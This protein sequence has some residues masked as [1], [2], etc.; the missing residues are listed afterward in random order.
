MLR[1][2]SILLGVT[3]G[4]AAY[5]AAELIRLLDKQGAMV[6]VV[7]TAAAQQFITP[8]TL[9]ALSGRPVLTDL[10]D[11]G[12]ESR[13]G[14]I[15]AAREADLILVAPATANLLA[16]MA[17]GLADDYLSTV[18][19]AATAPVIV[20]PAMNH[21]MYAN[22]ATQDN[23]RLL[24]NRGV[25]VVEPQAGELACGEEGQGRLAD[26]SL[27]VETAVRVLTPKSLQGKRVLVTAGPTWEPF[28]PV[29]FI[30]N[31][32][33]GKM[34]FALAVEAS[35]R[36]AHVDLVTGPTNLLDPPFL[37][38]HRVKTALEMDRVVRDLAATADVI[39]MSAAVSDYRPEETAPQK[40]KKSDRDLTIRLIRTPDILAGVGAVKRADQVLVGFAAETE[41]LIE[42]ATE[43]LRKKNL[44]FIVA[45]DLTRPGSGFRCDTNQVKILDRGGQ[46]DTLPCLTKNEVAR[47]ILDRVETLLQKV[48]HE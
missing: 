10:F 7:M 34:G 41:N 24:K 37:S 16:K 35:R 38:T 22:P 8:L 9:Q 29:R 25:H 27:I 32:S 44:D 13:I 4:I 12:M 17:H 6:Q 43:K 48:D 11:L 46:V 42:N 23:L 18:I 36:G 31:P 20:C 1:G 39:V 15:Q 33:S 14:H 2:K 26:L 5:K 30:T 28:D 3:G 19:L 45:N 47:R 40:V 21:V